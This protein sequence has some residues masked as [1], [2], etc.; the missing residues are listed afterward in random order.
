MSTLFLVLLLF[1]LRLSCC[2]SA[3]FSLNDDCALNV[4]DFLN[5][6][7]HN[8]LKITSQNILNLCKKYNNYTT[9][10][11]M[12]KQLFLILDNAQCINESNYDDYSN[13]IN[14]L[15]SNLNENKTYLHGFY[16]YHL[17]QI[18]TKLY[19][20]YLSAQIESNFARKISY[21]LLI[22]GCFYGG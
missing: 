4:I 17:L 3:N 9:K 12:M 7:D 8:T 2:L 16:R 14:L 1:L 20:M 22:H 21:S 13:Y 6:Q 15:V 5:I 10:Y 11:I 19:K 18:L